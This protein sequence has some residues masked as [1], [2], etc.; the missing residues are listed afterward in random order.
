MGKC[1]LESRRRPQRAGEKRRLDI[2]G[3]N[4]LAAHLAGSAATAI[5]EAR[6]VGR[7]GI[8]V[9]SKVVWIGRRRSR[10]ERGGLKPRQ[11]A[12]N[13]VAGIVSSG[14]TAECRRPAF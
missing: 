3:K 1:V 14:A 8:T 13:D 7:H 6:D 12:R 11:K 2:V 4:A 9:V 10:R 5:H